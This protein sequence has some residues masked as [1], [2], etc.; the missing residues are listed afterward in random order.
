MPKGMLT[1]VASLDISQ[2]WPASKGTSSSDG[3]T[4]HLK[5]DPATSF[6]FSSSPGKKPKIVK[7]FV[8]SYVVD[9]KTKKKLITSKSEIK[10]RLQGIDTPELHL[11][12]IGAGPW[13]PA[14][15]PLRAE[16]RQPFGAG[17]ANA[18]HAHLQTLLTG[19]GTVLHATFVTQVDNPAQAIDSHGRFVGDVIVGTA[20]SKSINTW[21][22][23][24]GWAYPLFYDS[25]TVPELNALVTAWKAGKT[26]AARP[27]K[28]IEKPLQP[29]NP[30]V[31]VNNAK[32]PDSGKLNYPK[33]FRRQAAFWTQVPG[34]L[35]GADLLAMEKK[36]Q[37]GKSDLAYP[38][39]YFLANINNLK[40]KNRI[41]LWT[42][43]GAQGQ[44]NFEPPDLVFKE[45]TTKL[46]DASGNPVTKFA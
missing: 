31:N 27:G 7:D 34:P 43:I 19:G 4:V 37:K 38:L 1:V 29:F 17:A 44:T 22:V 36:G 8:G 13:N 2:F 24:N 11:P 10:I 3:D 20:G 25:M 21:L 35:S 39:A 12:V 32:L 28:A 15:V 46:F 30:K 45:D 18:L 16:Y 42:K 41:P 6:L 26:L 23:E 14:K 9:H 33:I 5:V 40:P